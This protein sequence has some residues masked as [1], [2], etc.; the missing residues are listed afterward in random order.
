MI[1]RIVF[2]WLVR[3]L[4]WLVAG[5][6]VVGRENLPAKGPA[7]I[8][9]NHNSHIDT[10]ILLSLFEGR[11]LQIARP[12][13]AADYFMGNAFI[14]W[15]AQNV[16]SIIPLQRHS[17]GGKRDPLKPIEEAL[18]ENA[19]IILYPEGSRGLPEQFSDFK[20]GIAHLAQRC[21]DV[22]VI[23]VAIQ[24]AG[25]ALPKGGWVPVPYTCSVAIGTPFSWSGDRTH[26]MDTLKSAIRDLPQRR[27]T[28]GWSEYFTDRA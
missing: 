24:G 2:A 20:T 9:A 3:P 11:R 27:W 8:A 26:F 17:V 1:K 18:A 15:V 23:P 5:Q 21:P 28:F 4:L 16:L 12:V 22:P 7:I 10:L 25:R 13:A 19:I 14:R 6:S